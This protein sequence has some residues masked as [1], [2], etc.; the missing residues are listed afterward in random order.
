VPFTVRYDFTSGSYKG[1]AAVVGNVTVTGATPA[2]AGLGTIYL[3]PVT[4]AALGEDSATAG[5]NDTVTTYDPPDWQQRL[6]NAG[7]QGGSSG[8]ISVTATIRGK[9]ITDGFAS[10][11]GATAMVISYDFL[12]NRDTNETVATAAGSF[13]NSCKFRVDFSVKSVSIEGPAA[14]SPL[15]SLLLPTLQAA[16]VVPTKVTFWSTSA[17]PFTLPKSITVMTLPA[18][19]GVTTTT[20]ELT[21]FT[22]APR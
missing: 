1:A 7:I 10:L 2:Q 12:I 4:G 17:I 13:P 16:F 20:Q 19:T 3:D 18:P 6:T 9:S 14:S 15:L 8:K 5:S 21:A 22:V 11:G